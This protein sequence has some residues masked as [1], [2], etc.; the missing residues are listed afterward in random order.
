MLPSWQL[1][2]G[3]QKGTLVT[4]LLACHF[5]GQLPIHLTDICTLAYD[6]GGRKSDC[7]YQNSLRLHQNSIPPSSKVTFFKLLFAAAIVTALPVAVEPVNAILSIPG[8]SASATPVSYPQPEGYFEVSDCG[9]LE[10]M[11]RSPFTTLNTP[12]GNPASTKSSAIFW[13]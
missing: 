8:C 12:G 5:S 2:V 11:C 6:K 4:S 3:Q 9:N 7:Q 1:A 10:K 13:L